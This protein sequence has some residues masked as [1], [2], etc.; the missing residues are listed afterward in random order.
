M[1]KGADIILVTTASTNVSD[2]AAAS[3]AYI[4]DHQ[5]APVMSFSYGE[6]ELDLGAGGNAFYEAL[7]Q[8]AAAEGISV[9]VASGDE[10]SAGCDYGGPPLYGAQLGLAVSGTSSTP[11]DIS[12]GGTDLNWVNRPATSY[13]AAGSA[14][15]ANALGYIPEVPWNSSCASLAYGQWTGA[16]G[17]GL[18]PEQYCNLLLEQK[19][20]E[21]LYLIGGGGGMSACTTPGNSSP[22]SCA[23]GY[24]KPVWQSGLGVPADGRRDVPDVSLFAANGMLQTAYVVCDSASAPCNYAVANDA[25]AQAV[26]GTSVAS[27]A[28]AGIMALVNHKMGTAQGNAN[29]GLYELAALDNRAA[30]NTATVSAGN[31]CNF[32]DIAT[33][34]NAMPCV[35]GSKNC[36]LAHAG[37]Q[38]GILS[39][40]GATAGYDLST[41]LGTVNAANLVNNWHLTAAV[42]S[43]VAVPN[44]IGATE[45]AAATALRGAGLALGTVTQQVDACAVTGTVTSESPAAGTLIP[46]GAAVGLVVAAAASKV[47][48]PNTIGMS[49]AAAGS[50]LGAAGLDVGAITRKSS[51]TVAAGFVLG[52]SPAAGVSV[53]ACSSVSLVISSGHS[54][55]LVPNTVDLTT[56]AAARLLTQAGLSLGSIGQASSTSVR[57]GRVISQTPR[58]GSSVAPGAEVSLTVSRGLL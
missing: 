10:G 19:S 54:V 49:Q 43:T 3:A 5:I 57:P 56:P 16:T 12:V 26:G 17:R 32:Y 40:Y 20:T 31:A 41:G 44:E 30:C 38:L 15:D 23:G 8:Q 39:G 35:A 27:P 51:A 9:F 50:A 55:V 52:E 28:M 1:A 22:A 29:A 33:D 48:V 37:D 13:W 42:Q 58:A 21:A 6:C 25:M 36:A 45:S 46:A 7:W 18:D 34:S 2:G 24:A 53:A 14:G 4:I 47:T 11:Y